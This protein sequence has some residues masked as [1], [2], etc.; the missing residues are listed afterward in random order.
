MIFIILRSALALH[1]A[2]FLKWYLL[3][4]FQSQFDFQNA[5]HSAKNHAL[6]LKVK[7]LA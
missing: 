3:I 1:F 2:Q 7:S 5:Y 4:R 6:H